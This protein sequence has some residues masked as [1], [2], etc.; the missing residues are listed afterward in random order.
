MSGV[1]DGSLLPLGTLLVLS[2]D[3]EGL[4]TSPFP[5]LGP[6]FSSCK[7]K[8]GQD[9]LKVPFNFDLWFWKPGLLV[10]NLY[11]LPFFL[12]LPQ[13]Y[14]PPVGPPCFF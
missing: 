12:L 13:L 4:C 8:F 9:K 14:P 7:M 1:E 3:A 10:P 5:S 2:E 6:S 11:S